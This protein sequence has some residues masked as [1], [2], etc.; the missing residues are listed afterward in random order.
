MWRLFI[1]KRGFNKRTKGFVKFG[2][3]HVEEVDLF[4]VLFNDTN[5]FRA[6][7]EC[8][9]HACYHRGGGI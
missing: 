8:V 3:D 1:D 5:G 4:L 7:F 2:L 9:N 6:Y